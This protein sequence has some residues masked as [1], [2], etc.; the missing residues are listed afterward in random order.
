MAMAVAGWISWVEVRVA[1]VAAP[2]AAARTRAR[3]GAEGVM[4]ALVDAV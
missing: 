1:V 4:H 2:A 3:A